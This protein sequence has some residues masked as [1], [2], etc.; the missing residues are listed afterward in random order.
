MLEVLN[1]IQQ[2]I[3]QSNISLEDQNDLLVILPILP[4]KVLDNLYQ[5][6]LKN[7]QLIKTLD[8]AFKEKIQIISQQDKNQEKQWDDIIEQ[9][10]KELLE[11]ENLIEE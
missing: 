10:E 4:E 8:I 1:K 3:S 9:E 7:P 5:N 11:K 2:M 6:I